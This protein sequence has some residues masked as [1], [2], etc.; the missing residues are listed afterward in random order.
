MCPRRLREEAEVVRRDVPSGGHPL[1]QQRTSGEVLR[2]EMA[3]RQG[4]KVLSREVLERDN[5]PS[6][7]RGAAR[8]M[9]DCGDEQLEHLLEK[10]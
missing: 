2:R 6:H 7:G 3:R 4:R 9:A 1:P 10:C 5:R 8:R